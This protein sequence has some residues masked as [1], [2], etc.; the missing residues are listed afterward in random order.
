MFSHP[1]ATLFPPK[2]RPGN[3]FPLHQSA[4]WLNVLSLGTCVALA[5]SLPALAQTA[6]TFASTSLLSDG[7]VPALVTDTN[8][9]NPWGISIGRDFWI[10][11]AS[12]GLDYVALTTGAISFKVT[13]P[14]ASGKTKGSPSGTV[15]TGGSKAFVLPNGASASFLFASLDGTLSGWNGGLGLDGSIAQV[16]VNNGAAGAV[17]TD[18][19]LVTNPT[20]TF[21]LA[22]NFG[23]ASSI[24]VFD[25]AFKPAK[26]SGTFTDPNLPA[27][28]GPFS[29]HSIGSQVV[30]TYAPRD[31]TGTTGTIYSP[32]VGPS[33]RQ[34]TGPGNG[35]V[36]VFDTSGN[37]ITRAITAGN[38]NDPWGVVVAPATFGVYAGALLIGNFGDG[39]IN[40]YDAKT[41]AYLGQIIDG[42]GK[43]IANPGLWEIVFGVPAFGDVDSLYFAAGGASETHGL[44]GAIK[45]SPSATGAAAFG[46]STSSPAMTVKAGGSTQT[47]ISVAPTNAFSGNVSLACTG[48]PAGATCAFG[49]TSLSVTPTAVATTTLTIQ[50]AGQSALG[51]SDLLNRH[52][53]EVG[54]A[55]LLPFGSLLMG[56]RRMFGGRPGTRWLLAVSVLLLGGLGILSGCSGGSAAP[57]STTPASPVTGTSQ[58]TVT[59]TSGAIT[60]SA[61]LTLIVN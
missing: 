40:A 43:P 23:G 20:G 45:S 44:L 60:Q 7:S 21:I 47:T 19:A 14:S 58:V 37:F 55:L 32:G 59:A 25:S 53:S 33:Y 35:V 13:V 27:G 2:C 22:S 10:N 18:M 26:L 54:L 50:T 57:T 12:T 49:S 41:F 16:V 3:L 61:G 42:A 6:G 36:D 8:F 46:F 1:A 48:L 30:I 34:Q 51:Q 5:T 15:F 11:T 24:D 39:V 17:Y 52:L 56:R 38:L 9:V 28:Y 31:T 29:V 4:R